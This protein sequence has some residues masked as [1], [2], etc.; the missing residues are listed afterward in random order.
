M[1]IISG[2]Y[3][4]RRL[5]SPPDDTTRP[6]PDRVK[7]SLFNLL[8]GHVEG[9][10]VFDGFAGTGSIGLEALSRGAVFCTFV[11]RDKGAAALLRENIETLGANDRCDVVTGDALGPSALSR[12]RRPLHLAF[13]DP[14]YPMWDTPQ[15]RDRVMHQGAALASI[16][17][18]D[19]FLVVRTPW[20]ATVGAL[21][22]R[23]EIDLRHDA[24]LGPE[25]HEYGTTALH[26]YAPKR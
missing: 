15:G 6:I 20:P 19:G 9:V 8:R 7:E 16:L 26:L 18:D 2:E 17:D 23:R 5:K 22:D 24:L 13:L 12:A 1:R 25:T 10:N 3:K 4:S 21:D 14:P 11:E